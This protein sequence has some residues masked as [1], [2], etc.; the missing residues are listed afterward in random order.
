[1]KKFSLGD[2]VT[3]DRDRFENHASISLIADNAIDWYEMK[4]GQIGVVIGV[5]KKGTF[6]KVFFEGM[7]GSCFSNSLIFA[8]QT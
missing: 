6:V 5:E 8:N 2:L 4:N 1:M 7:S 3:P